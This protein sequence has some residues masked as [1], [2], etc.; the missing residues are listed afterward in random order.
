MTREL[1]EKAR[2]AK[3]P[4]ELL[5]LAREN[6]IPELTGTQRHIL[7]ACINREN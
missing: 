5:K 4:E 6:G 7:R 1:L 3:S 2:A